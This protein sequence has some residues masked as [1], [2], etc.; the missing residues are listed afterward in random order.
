MDRDRNCTPEQAQQALDYL[1][2]AFGG[3]EIPD[4]ERRAHLRM[5]LNFPPQTIRKAIDELVRKSDRRPSPNDIAQM[6]RGGRPRTP[7]TRNQ[8][9]WPESSPESVSR[10]LDEIRATNGIRSAVKVQ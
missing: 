2:H 3:W 8:D 4:M 9:P 7:D 1:R 5:F 6:A 10:H